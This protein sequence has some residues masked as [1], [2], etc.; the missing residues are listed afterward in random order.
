MIKITV[1]SLGKLKEKYFIDA[2]LE[3]Q[4]RLLRY[5]K[6]DII[7]IEPIKLSENPSEAEI[8]SALEKEADFITKKI[9]NGSK[10]FSLCV[11][12]RQLTS[13]EFADKISKISDFGG[14]LCFII[15]S[16]YGLSENI[17]QKS[18]F[19]LSLSEMTFPHK[20]FRV[21]LLEQIYRGFKI[22]EGSKYH[23]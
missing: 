4:K 21:M 22:I 20:L 16:S 11:E 18:D 2:A 23:K 3:Y 14:S 5:C 7:E 12:G 6:L 8:K 19:R 9:P 15:G 1:I 17:K 13:P 10:V